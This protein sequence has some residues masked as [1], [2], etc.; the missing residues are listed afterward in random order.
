MLIDAVI[1]D[2]DGTLI[3]SMWMWGSI[4]ERFLRERGFEVP[5]GL[6]KIIE[7][8]SIHETAV[9]FIENY[10]LPET[11]EELCDIWTNMAID[12]YKNDV[13]P[14]VGA[15]E[16]LK[17]L[18]EL[19]IKT[20]IASSNTTDLIETTLESCGLAPYIDVYFS[21]CMIKC[22][23]PAPDIYLEAAKALGVKPERCLCFEDI[24]KGLQAGKAA[25]MTCACIKDDYCLDKP[26]DIAALADYRFDDFYEAF[27]LIT[28]R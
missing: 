18:K 3:D 9:W 11:P 6:Q 20:A 24:V 17:K 1:F 21:G 14:K 23:K 7:G 28:D 16:F 2:M 10:N 19:G 4:D 13:K 12:A 8:C 22:G 5:D 26:E 15:M 27:A 25:G